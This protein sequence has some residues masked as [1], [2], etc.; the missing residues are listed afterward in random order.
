MAK[1]LSQRLKILIESKKTVFRAKDLQSLWQENPRNTIV[2][3]KRMVAKNLILKLAKG[4]YALNEEYNIYELA[5]L[6][7]SPSYVSLNSALLF[8]GACFQVSGTVQSIALLNYQKEVGDRIFKYQA[9][10]KSLFFNPDGMDFKN[11]ISVASPERAL[12]DSF[13]FGVA[14]N[15]DDWEKINKTYL[16]KLAQSYPLSVQKK[17]KSLKL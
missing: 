14:V 8:W 7:I 11:N 9:M 5:N 10:K 12:L 15:I 6:I 3:A 2:I 4:Y 13:Y 1:N 16:N 17:V